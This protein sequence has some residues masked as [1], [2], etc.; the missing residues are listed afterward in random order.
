[1]SG[2]RREARRLVFVL[3]AA[4]LTPVCA[5][6]G[7]LLV[8]R[9]QG[10]QLDSTAQLVTIIVSTVFVTSAAGFALLIRENRMLRSTVAQLNQRVRQYQQKP[11]PER[12]F[13]FI[14]VE[15]AQ[16]ELT[17]SE[18]EL[19]AERWEPEGQ[20]VKVKFESDD[21]ADFFVKLISADEYTE[22]PYGGKHESGIIEYSMKGVQSWTKD[23]ESSG[24]KYFIVASR[25]AS[26]RRAF[27][28]VQI[29][30]FEFRPVHVASK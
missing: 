4:I 25:P 23:F 21:D 16:K 14:Q 2:W 13:D 30:V 22:G 1:M 19:V 11:G 18:P 9:L 5:Y 12:I 7:T 20:K 17:Q 10:I 24:G 28:G 15:D 29:Q 8:N 26:A 27:L 3:I 6:I